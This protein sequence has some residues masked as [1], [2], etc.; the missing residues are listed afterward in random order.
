MKRNKLINL[1]EAKKE[2]LSNKVCKLE[3]TQEGTC[4]VAG[5][6]FFPVQIRYHVFM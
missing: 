2:G 4:C 1:P 5:V 3:F 6:L